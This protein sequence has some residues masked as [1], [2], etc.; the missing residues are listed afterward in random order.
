MKSTELG[1]SLLFPGMF[2]CR[3]HKLLFFFTLCASLG[4]SSGGGFGRH[5]C[6][7]SALTQGLT[8]LN[9]TVVP[10]MDD[11]NT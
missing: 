5:C 2:G 9:F 11:L 1:E 4:G 6:A 7:G 8:V 3:M 10:V